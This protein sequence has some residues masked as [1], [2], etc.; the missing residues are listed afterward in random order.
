MRRY[1]LTSDVGVGWR[2]VWQILVVA[3]VL[4]V[5]S[6]VLLFADAGYERECSMDQ[7][8]GRRAGVCGSRLVDL[9]RVICRSVYNKRSAD[10]ENHFLLTFFDK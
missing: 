4:L 3:T 5:T 1:L 10:C 6:G 7:L 2:R 9:L 8:N